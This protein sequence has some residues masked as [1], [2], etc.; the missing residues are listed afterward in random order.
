MKFFCYLILLLFLP[1]WQASSHDLTCKQW[2][3]GD[4]RFNE[5]LNRY[6]SSDKMGT[7]GICTDFSPTWGERIKLE[8][9]S[10]DAFGTLYQITRQYCTGRNIFSNWEANQRTGEMY[11]GECR[12]E[13]FKC[14][15]GGWDPPAYTNWINPYVATFHADAVP[16]NNSGMSKPHPFRLGA[17]TFRYGCLEKVMPGDKFKFFDNKNNSSV[18]IICG[19]VFPTET[20]EPS[21]FW[22]VTNAFLG[23][24]DEPLKPGPRPY[25]DVLID[26][27]L[28]YVDE[29]KDLNYYLQLG[30][31]FDQ[32]V[33]QINFGPA[34]IRLRY[35]FSGDSKIIDNLPICASLGG[36]Y[37]AIVPE[38]SP[39]KICACYQGNC[40]KGIFLGCAPRP[41]LEQSGLKVHVESTTES[42]SFGNVF[43]AAKVQI[44]YQTADGDTIYVDNQKA[45]AYKEKDKYFLLKNGVKTNQEAKLPVRVK[46][47]PLSVKPLII[48][49]YYKLMNPEGKDYTLAK[50]TGSVYGVKFGSIIPEMKGDQPQRIKVGTPE[51]MLSTTGCYYFA[52]LP[53]NSNNGT[54]YYVPAGKRDTTKCTECPRDRLEICLVK[55]ARKC[56]TSDLL[57][58]NDEEAVRAYCPG[59]YEGSKD[60]AK[61]DS[62][63]AINSTNFNFITQKK[64]LCVPL[65]GTCDAQ[66]FANAASGYAIFSKNIEAGQKEQGTCDSSLGFENSIEYKPEYLDIANVQDQVKAKEMIELNDKFEVDFKALQS[67]FDKMNMNIPKDAIDSLVAKY[68]DKI[69]V[70]ATEVQPERSCSSGTGVG[71]IKG[72]CKVRAG[73]NAIGASQLSGFAK[74]PASLGASALLS[75]AGECIEGYKTVA[76]KPSLQCR[77]SESLK[78]GDYTYPSVN[79]WDFSTLKNPCQKE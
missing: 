74:F 60:P 21:L 17:D 45:D 76:N 15:P 71:T 43:P 50:G 37:C 13:F 32:P 69:P 36:S 2:L 53:E 3:S 54:Y 12:T 26:E 59:L 47:L 46:A 70:K 5:G 19:Y 33:I 23:C 14:V 4:V 49:E 51:E 31:T 28:P 20:C 56:E 52:K 24:V 42:D 10:E 41:N 48:K 77:A 73:C 79:Y 16:A 61:P 58:P 22:P 78:I 25:N 8:R 63:C 39:D 44:A 18:A 68:K 1:L 7:K 11:C 27:V 40:E 66:L 34:V 75:I 57:F 65:S 29:T 64:D 30:S 55:P 67:H 62:I 35:K 38:N 72:R 6:V 9:T